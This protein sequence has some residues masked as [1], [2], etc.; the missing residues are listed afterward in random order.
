MLSETNRFGYVNWL[1]VPSFLSA[2]RVRNTAELLEKYQRKVVAGSATMVDYCSLDILAR[3]AYASAFL[4]RYLPGSRW[5]HVAAI[6]KAINIIR[7]S[8][9]E[10]HA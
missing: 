1:T 8:K 3:N 5:D 6:R 4:G 7:S 2:C 10:S 9:G